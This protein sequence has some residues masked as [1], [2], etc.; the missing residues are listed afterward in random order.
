MADKL[1]QKLKAPQKCCFY[2]KDYLFC[3]CFWFQGLATL[4]KMDQEII[5]S[6]NAE[7][8]ELT[9]KVEELEKRD[10]DKN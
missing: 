2:Y 4:H 9:E 6:L 8:E 7:N 10:E 3:K 5:K 1:F